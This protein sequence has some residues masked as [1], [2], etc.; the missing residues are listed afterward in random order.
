[1]KPWMLL[2]SLASSDPHG[3]GGWSARLHVVPLAE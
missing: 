1:M 3:L 2:P